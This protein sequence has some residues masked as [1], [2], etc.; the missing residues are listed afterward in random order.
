M[1]KKSNDQILLFAKE[2]ATKLYEI[3]WYSL[4]EEVIRTS[5]ITISL[6]FM[7]RMEEARRE[8]CEE[9]LKKYFKFSEGWY[10]SDVRIEEIVSKATE[11]E[12]LEAVIFCEGTLWETL[13]YYEAYGSKETK[14]KDLYNMF[15][16]TIENH[17]MWYEWGNGKIFLYGVS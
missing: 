15:V 2:L 9:E 12:K 14:V 10:K 11:D 16:K 6:D 13:Y 7:V 1:G 5:D 3:G 17:G 8:G 4:D